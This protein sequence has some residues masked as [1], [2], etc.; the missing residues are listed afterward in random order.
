M[1]TAA[2]ALQISSARPSEGDLTDVR[3]ALLTIDEHIRATMLFGGPPPLDIPFHKLSKTAAQILVFVMKRHKWTVNANLMAQE[4]RF[5]AGHS[6]P[7]H[8]FLQFQP[9][10]DVYDELLADMSFERLSDA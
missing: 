6:E 4:S 10:V 5:R 7:H 2:E 9:T 1:I 3:A 8:W